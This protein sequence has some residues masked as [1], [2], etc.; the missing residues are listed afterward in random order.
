MARLQKTPDASVRSWCFTLWSQ[1][2]GA[3][4]EK[5]K[6]MKKPASQ[7]LSSPCSIWNLGASSRSAVT[8]PAMRPVT[9]SSQE[10]PAAPVPDPGSSLPPPPASPWMEPDRWF[11][12]AGCRVDLV[13][14]EPAEALIPLPVLWLPQNPGTA[15]FQSS[16]QGCSDPNGSH[17]TVRGA[18]ASG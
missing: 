3:F 13:A 6:N 12:N 10:L 5:K 18:V 11:N 17:T 9:S 4:E 16:L 15:E 1:R 7:L 14:A 2:L 8:S